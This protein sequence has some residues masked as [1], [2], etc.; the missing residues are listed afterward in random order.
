MRIQFGFIYFFLLM[1][2][3]GQS[4]VFAIFPAL[5]RELM[6]TELQAGLVISAAAFISFAVSPFWGRRVDKAGS[7]S[8]LIQG[9]A[10]YGLFNM[11]FAGVLWMAIDTTMSVVAVFL[12][13]VLTRCMFAF[14]T[15]AI[16]P[17]AQTYLITH[18]SAE[19]RP[20]KMAMIGMM[21]GLGMILGPA[22][23][24]AL[25]SVGILAPIVLSALIMLLPL[26][27]AVRQLHEVPVTQK[28]QSGGAEKLRFRDARIRPYFLL[29][30]TVYAIFSAIQ[31]TIAFSLQDL[32]SFDAVATAQ[33][34][35]IAFMVC[36]VA[37]VICQGVI[38]QKWQFSGQQLIT[39][40]LVSILIS[41]TVFIAG[42]GLVAVM[43]AFAALGVGFGFVYPG[44]VSK[45][46]LSVTGQLQGQV[47]GALQAAM[48]L[49]FIVGPLIGAGLYAEIG[50]WVYGV[51]LCLLVSTSLYVWFNRTNREE[52]EA[53]V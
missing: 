11:A 35:G 48:S 53:L 25:V 18:T 9:V 7:K 5:S 34:V 38:I 29:M 26:P 12:L 13:L 39:I 45:A 32:L 24:S 8:S 14:F 20:A 10:G 27:F 41:L 1:V 42:Q 22:A 16:L 31:Q 3:A 50:Q 43:I 52:T 47:T 4:I 37:S 2:G 6:M 49:G 33:W 15:S 40:G 23:G 51:L 46:S 36:A 17:A 30:L 28:Q 44:I 21:F 19:E